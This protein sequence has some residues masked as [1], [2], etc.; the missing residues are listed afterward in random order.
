MTHVHQFSVMVVENGFV[1]Q[2]MF[3]PANKCITLVA[4]NEDEL[5]ELLR[6]YIARRKGD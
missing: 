6:E 3:A 1:V 2:E 4:R 5:I